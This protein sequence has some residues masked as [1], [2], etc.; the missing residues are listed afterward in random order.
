[1]N[2][3]QLMS[4]IFSDS[5]PD[6]F[7]DAIS[8]S[9]NEAV[10]N[11]QA[12]YSEDGEQ[13]YFASVDGN[14][15]IEDKKNGNEVTVATP[16]S[17][18]S[19]A[20]SSGKYE[21]KSQPSAIV[22][23]VKGKDG[24]HI[25]NTVPEDPSDP[26]KGEVKAIIMEAGVTDPEKAGVGKHFSVT[27][28][29]FESEDEAREFSENVSAMD[30]VADYAADL[31]ENSLT[32]SDDEVANVSFSANDLQK[33]VERL[34]GTRDLELAFSII[35]D[36]DDLR[37]Y[38]VLAEQYGHDMDDVIE[39]CNSYSDYASDMIGEI[40]ADTPVN[41]YFSELDQDEVNDY[42][43]ELDDVEASVLNEALRSGENYTFSDVEEAIDQVYSDIEMDTPITEY[44]SDATED[45]I[46]DFFSDLTDEEQN[47]V[48][49]M[50]E[51]DPN[52]SFSDVNEVFD[53]M[54]TPLSEMFSDYTEDD[55]N[56]MFS[57]MTDDEVAT[58]SDMLE[59]GDN[60]CYSDLL[61]ALDEA[62]EFSEDDMEVLAQNANAIY[63]AYQDFLA[64][65]TVDLAEQINYYS[66]ATLSDCQKA[67]AN[68]F[69]VD[70]VVEMCN[71]YSDETDAFC[72]Q[73]CDPDG[74]PKEVSPKPAAPAIPANA[75]GKPA[76]VE[77][78]VKSDTNDNGT[79]V[80]MFSESTTP[81]GSSAL[82]PCLTSPIN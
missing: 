59:D 62:R 81:A 21:A 51:E 74:N 43:S 52:T 14:V 65:P 47:I 16:G 38:S 19:M 73:Y 39:A 33:D 15:V 5:T 11:G 10:L 34:A 17:D 1:M 76:T 60:Y 48:Y 12:T 82:N 42:F 13:L 2:D 71:Q 30:D 40:I 22:P 77:N 6:A 20:L 26:S 46:N 49:S 66:D 4:K 24:A 44:F 29:G 68:G 32:F 63:S 79:G 56:E 50:I 80:R 45:E 37:S 70:D 58:F 27:F 8:D 78:V 7:K 53:E 72:D 61:D 57:D 18:G 64:E 54:Y 31:E 9:I 28:D 35:D 23:R 69:D 67:Y 36:A 41:E 25:A 75:T 55:F 3:T